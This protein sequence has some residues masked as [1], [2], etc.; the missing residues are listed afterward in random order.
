MEWERPTEVSQEPMFSSETEKGS[1]STTTDYENTSSNKI[2][3]FEN[4]I[5]TIF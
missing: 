4:Q 5:L 2:F 3:T 1:Q